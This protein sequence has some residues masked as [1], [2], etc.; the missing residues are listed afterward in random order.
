MIQKTVRWLVIFS[1][2][3]LAMHLMHIVIN[4][5]KLASLVTGIHRLA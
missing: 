2:V 1:I 5:E 3:D 4:A